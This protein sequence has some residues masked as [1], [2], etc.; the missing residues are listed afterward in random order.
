MRKMSG[1]IKLPRHFP[2]IFQYKVNGT[3]YA[4]TVLE[5]GDSNRRTDFS[6]IRHIVDPR[7]PKN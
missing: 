2:P 3:F 1:D 5:K 6:G 4:M 7:I